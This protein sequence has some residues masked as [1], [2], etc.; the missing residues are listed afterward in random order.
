MK[1]TEKYEIVEMVTSG[2]VSTFLARERATQEPVVVYTFACESTGVSTA[3]IISR[4]CGL[5]PN[6]PGMIVKAGYDET[7]S[8]AF[9]AT[10]MPESAALKEW[11]Q[12]YQSFG[13]PE[14]FGK[15]DA[16]PTA[17]MPAAKPAGH[18]DET[19]EISPEELKAALAKSA[20]PAKPQPESPFDELVQDLG[21]QTAVFSTKTPP[22]S[23]QSSGEFTRLFREVGAFQAIPESS[24]KAGDATA[25][26]HSNTPAD[27]GLGQRLGGAPLGG[28]KSPLPPVTPPTS[29]EPSPGSFTQEFMA[30]N[31]TPPEPAAKPP[32]PAPV[33]SPGSFTRE[34]LGLSGLSESAPKPTPTQPPVETPGSFTKEFMGLSSK[35]SEPVPEQRRV[36]TPPPAQKAPGAFTSEFLAV[37]QPS[38]PARAS[39]PEPPASSSST[40]LF[41]N[42]FGP[43]TPKPEQPSG[44]FAGEAQS[45]QAGEGE[46]TKFF[47]DPFEHPQAASRPMEIPQ[48]GDTS[49]PRQQTGEFTR[50]FGREDIPQPGSSSLPSA[51]P[52]AAAPGSF[53]QLFGDVP[54]GKGSPLGAS[55]LGTNPNVR[56][57]FLEPAT[58]PPAPVAP[59][60]EPLFS[61]PP[62][63]P[64]DPFF[65]RPSPVP[66]AVN[67]PFMN[68]PGSSEATDVFRLPTSEAP[69]PEQAHGGPSEFTMFLSRG[70]V[71][72]AL[73]REAGVPA[74]PAVSVPP[75]AA[76]PP[77]PPNPFQ[78]APPPAPAPPAISYPQMPV[79]PVPAVPVL[80]P[81]TMP[82]IQAP[83]VAAPKPGSIWP[84]IAVLAI[85]VAVG[86]ILVMYFALK[87]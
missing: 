33:E 47:R 79:A 56:P 31:A 2:R 54:S 12:A 19:A 77:P 45:P 67:S 21:G 66:P 32:A 69:P 27:A 51:E 40:A 38:P 71:N 82:K 61:T 13:K 41:G 5:A 63:Q 3:A 28:E 85:L 8:S 20:V 22:S 24:T 11:V 58:P 30:L 25:A 81:P 35:P 83:A 78:F 84:V 39:Q 34:F 72:A 1:F 17:P 60:R 26:T 65:S 43:A 74:N 86:A 6:P 48:I 55:T 36:S 87:H 80:A 57:S 68:R 59:P 10:K 16:Q 37:S 75:F 29:A 64:A 9:L 44:N 7:S 46:F 4:F 73:Q 70:Q 53:T 50:M 62:A 42:I 14:A 23:P 49:P 76:P 52:G 15:P 18:S